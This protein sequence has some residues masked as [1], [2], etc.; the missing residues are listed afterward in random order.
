MSSLLERFVALLLLGAMSWPAFSA[1][2][3]RQYWRTFPKITKTLTVLLFCYILCLLFVVSAVSLPALRVLC[4][5]GMIVLTGTLWYAHNRFGRRR[6]W[7]PGSLRP[8]SAK[9]WFDRDFFFKEHQRLGSPFKCAQF[10]RPMVC[11]TGLAEG[12]EFLRIHDASLKSPPLP[13]GRFIPSGFLRHMAPDRHAETKAALR[14]ALRRKSI[15]H[16]NRSCGNRFVP[17]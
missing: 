5:A 11:L 12:F 13:F 3:S 2:A 4:A 6:R 1:I 7:P 15:A 16:Q 8:F 14:K 9:V 17:E 10:V